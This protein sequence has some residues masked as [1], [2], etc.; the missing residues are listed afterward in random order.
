MMISND[1][2]IE[3]ATDKDVP[4]LLTLIRGLAEYEKLSDRVSA[5][6]ERLRTSLFGERPYAEAIIAYKNDRPIA[7]AIYYFTYSSF[8]G[9]PRLYLE[10]LFVLPDSRGFGIGR[11][12]LAFLAE[13]AVELRCCRIEWAVLNWNEPAIRFYENLGAQPM[14]DWTVYRLSGKR[15]EEM[16]G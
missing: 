7:Y 9:L 6:E 16:A 2:R 15:L 5:T 13:K 14:N 12:L 8:Q 11:Q 4:L 3:Q 10:D 1:L